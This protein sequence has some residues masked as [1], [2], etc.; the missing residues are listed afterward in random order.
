M[1]RIFRVLAVASGCLLLARISAAANPLG[2]LAGIANRYKMP[3]QSIS[4]LVQDVVSARPLLAINAQVPRN[5]AS[6]LKLLTTFV[7]LDTLGPIYAWRTEVYA[8]G[9]INKGVLKGDLLLKGFGDPYLLEDQL[10]Q[11]LGELRRKGVQRITGDLVIDDSHFAPPASDPAAFDGQAY[12]LYNVLPNA[13]Q[14]N[15]K[16]VT[17]IFTPRA[18]GQGVLVRTNPEL[19]NLKITNQLQL[20]RGRCRGVLATVQLRVPDPVAADAVVLSGR[21]QTGCGEQTLPRTLLT[22]ASYAYG[23]FRRLW[24]QWGGVLEGGVRRGVQPA[25]TR[26]LLVW[27]SP[28]LA[29]LIRPLNK[30]SNNVMADALFYTLGGTQFEPP[31]RPEHAAS[32]VKSYLTQHRI[33]TAGFVMENGSGLSRVTRITAQTLHDV[34]HQ[35]YHSKYMPE[36][37][38]S[39]SIVGVDGTLRRRLK[40]GAETGWMHLKTGHLNNVAAVAG[41][42]RAQS[43]KTYAVVLFVN[44]ATG[45]SNALFDTF[46]R[47]VYRQ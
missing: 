31:L 4:A 36:Y 43:G 37:L 26:P 39:L 32:V 25:P 9:P 42:V 27:H 38:A 6:T 19:P 14:I 22:P 33:P 11:L 20:E 1:W 44:G 18:D 21:Y 24:A 35:A 15:F 45:G 41:Y 2:P 23:L 46:L 10:W 13:L 34:L 8:L 28:P 12:R 29:E 16:A 47:W 3:A 40:G 7:A 5:P 30:W 17:F